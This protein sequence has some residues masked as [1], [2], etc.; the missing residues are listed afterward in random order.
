[1]ALLEQPG[2][3]AERAQRS[4]DELQLWALT[5]LRYD[6]V[7][8]HVCVFRWIRM[9]AVA[10]EL[11]APGIFEY[12]PLLLSIVP[13]DEVYRPRPQM[14]PDGEHVIEGLYPPPESVPAS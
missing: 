14:L 8:Y 6:S 11:K 7:M 5:L 12:M 3:A 2:A 1:L 9:M 13:P 4:T 10:Y